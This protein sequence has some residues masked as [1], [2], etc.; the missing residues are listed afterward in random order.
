MSLLTEA[1]PWPETGRP[2]RA[3]VSSFGM[4]GTNAHVVLEQAPE[5]ASVDV[6]DVVDEDVLGMWAVSGRSVEALRAQ[7]GRL[8]EVLGRAD[9]VDVAGVGRALAARARLEHRAVLCG[10]GTELVAGLQA[11]SEGREHEGL[12]LGFAGAGRPRCVF[13]YPG[14][15]SQWPGMAAALYSSS[16]AFATRLRECAEAL[17]PFVDWPVLETL[18]SGS[19]EWSRTDVV[20][21]ALFAVMLGITAAWQDLGVVPDAV[22][23]HSQGEIAAAVAAGALSLEDGARL[24][25]LRARA[26]SGLSGTGAMASVP[27]PAA[28][29]PPGLEIAAINGPSHTVV[30]GPTATVAEFVA[31]YQARDVR[32]RLID[33]DYASHSVHIESLHSVLAELKISPRQARIPFY[34]TVTA[35][36]IT[37]TTVLDAEYWWQNLRQPVRFHDTVQ[38]LRVDGFGMF[39]ESSPHPVLVPA[40][41]HSFEGFETVVIGSL[42]RDH[43]GLR[44]LL[45][46]AARAHVHGAPLTPPGSTDQNP[47]LLPDLPT[48]PFQHT[49]Y[50]LLP[51]ASGSA[52]ALGLDPGGHPLLDAVVAHPDGGITGTAVLT[53]DR[54]AWI[55]DHAVYDMIVLPGA[56]L[57]ELV[58]HIAAGTGHPHLQ[59]LT[60]QAPLVLA[61]DDQLHLNITYRP[62]GTVTIHTRPADSDEPPTWT[63]HATAILTTDPAPEPDPIPVPQ[64][65]ATATAPTVLY[66]ELHD[67]GYHYGPTFQG[68]TD[69]RHHGHQAW[70]TATLPAVA[71]VDGFLLHPALMDAA[72]HTVFLTA[73]TDQP[74]ARQLPFTFTDTTIHRRPAPTTIGIYTTTE[75]PAHTI[76]ITGPDNAPILT[77]HLTTRALNPQDFAAPIDQSVFELNWTQIPAPVTP[78]PAA[79]VPRTWAAL[80]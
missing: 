3:G 8:A 61:E 13:V 38:A 33:V 15:G 79:D 70:A 29:L 40:L 71:A 23:G 35:A 48:Y 75:G 76:T 50:W 28:D 16:P 1:R 41:E 53:A 51:A 7:G 24:C 47:D 58:L 57:L 36:R 42:R 62:D 20:Q 45:G 22:V 31:Q 44:Q 26:L 32:A 12:T 55:R 73:D 64:P 34:S 60:L 39:I 21:P 11:L 6:V 77:T 25:A 37:D 56:A 46:N 69:I 65:D 63:H 9:G 10:S 80:G 78:P 68:L 72:L 59:E 67:R 49:R 74:A 17:Q 66:A 27:L 2:R 52:G 18:T 30:A 54:C 14:Q 43:D 4:S 5:P 19:G